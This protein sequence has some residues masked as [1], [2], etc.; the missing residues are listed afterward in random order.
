[1]RFLVLLLFPILVFAS[2]DDRGSVK[3]LMHSFLLEMSTVND[4]LSNEEAFAS[5]EGKK[6][7][8]EALAKME[9]AIRKP[10]KDIEE[11]PGFRISY[12]LLS[13]H[14]S[15]TKLLID[16]GELEYARARLNGTTNLCAGCHMQTPKFTKFSPFAPLKQQLEKPSFASANFLFITRR[17]EEALEQFNLLIR[18]Y[19]ESGLATDRLSEVYR[20]KLAFFARVQRDAGYA[21]TNL[22]EDLK[23]K[24]L[25]KDIQQNVKDWIQSFEKW[26]Q[27]K[28]NP[29]DLSTPDLI[30][31]AAKEIPQ[32]PI[33]NIAA[34]DPQLAKFLRI[35]GL[36]YERLYSEPDAAN[37]QALLYYLAQCERS[38]SPLYWY[39]LNEVYL[40][41]CVTKYPKQPFSKRCFEAYKTGMEERF[42]GR[43]MPEPIRDSIAALKDAAG[44]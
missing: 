12:G 5:E 33:R 41:E 22:Q 38:L 7:I 16:K 37:A 20:K 24:N 6:K 11:K 8:K 18:K 34:G 21:I 9:R 29:A 28:T 27:E 26:K 4:V 14:I 19:P 1:M 15:K 23:N 13:D 25:P 43:P 44:A 40:K 31:Y 3:V 35:S 2:N 36:L 32:Q 39:S 42:M 30:K 17:Y 10:P